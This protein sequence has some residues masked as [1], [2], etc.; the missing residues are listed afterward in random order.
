MKVSVLIP[1]HMVEVVEIEWL[2]QAIQSVIDQTYKDWECVIVND[3]SERRMTW[4]KRRFSKVD[5]IRFSDLTKDRHGVSAARNHA[6]FIATGELLL[7]LDHDDFLEPDAL[8]WLVEAWQNHKGVVYGDLKLFGRDS[9]KTWKSKEGCNELIKDVVAWNT[10]LFAKEDWLKVGGWNEN[11][12]YLDDWDLNIKFIEHEICLHHVSRVIAWYRQRTDS[13][14]ARLKAD[15]NAWAK[16]YAELRSYHTDFF[17]GRLK[18]MCCGSQ[19]PAPPS[20]E[21]VKVRAQAAPGGRI[22]IKYVGARG[23]SFGMR[24]QKTNVAYMVPGSGEYI[25]THPDGLTG[26]DPAD[27]ADILKMNGGKDFIQV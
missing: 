24:G 9:E 25:V 11:L 2:T 12:A 6:A 5:N 1:V 7:P 20:G 19:I 3:A 8:S 10:S 4:A 17:N 14:T 15:P 16:A 22:L 13:R 27:A 18:S 23:G 26:V 21:Q